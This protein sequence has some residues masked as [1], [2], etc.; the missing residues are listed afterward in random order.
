MDRGVQ[1]VPFAFLRGQQHQHQIR[2]DAEILALIGDDHGLEIL[3]GLLEARVQHADLIFAQRV[4][5]AVELDAQHAV[6]Q[7]DQ[8]R[9]RVLLHD[10][11]RPLD[12]GEHQDPG[13]SS[14]R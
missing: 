11:A 8:R 5:L 6:A 1:L 3:L 9:A 14:S 12:V 10:A 2:A 7:V 4:H 13:R